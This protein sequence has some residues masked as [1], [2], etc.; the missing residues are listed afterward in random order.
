MQHSEYTDKYFP[1]L[2]RF[3]VMTPNLGTI[4][5]NCLLKGIF[6]FFWWFFLSKSVTFF[7]REF[8]PTPP[9]SSITLPKEFKFPIIPFW[10][11]WLL[12]SKKLKKILNRLSKPGKILNR[13]SKSDK[14]LNWLSKSGKI[15]NQLSKFGE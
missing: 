1:I 5:P 13:L 10:I 8:F 9:K 15:F 11:L 4:E 3:I 2:Y 6:L 12:S 7:S 14:I